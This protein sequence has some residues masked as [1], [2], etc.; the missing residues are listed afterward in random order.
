MTSD[1]FI[2]FFNL[3]R[4][5][6]SPQAFQFRFSSLNA[7]I[8]I[9]VQCKILTSVSL[10]KAVIMLFTL[11]IALIRWQLMHRQYFREIKGY[12]CILYV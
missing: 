3:K 6:F 4:D 8:K 7:T 2:Y 10:K 12:S 11:H 5:F 1:F 9:I